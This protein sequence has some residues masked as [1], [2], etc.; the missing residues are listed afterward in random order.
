MLTDV[1][2]AADVVAVFF[3]LA[4]FSVVAVVAIGVDSAAALL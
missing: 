3:L 4:F 2:A 1:V